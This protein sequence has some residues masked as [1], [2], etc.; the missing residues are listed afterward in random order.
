[1]AMPKGSSLTDFEFTRRYNYCTIDK[2]EHLK[3]FA[4]NSK[5][6]SQF[7]MLIEKRKENIKRR[8]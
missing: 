8:K 2:L 6:V 4:K 3:K 1:M 7:D 5:A